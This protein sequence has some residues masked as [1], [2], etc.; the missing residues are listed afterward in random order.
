MITLE[1]AIQMGTLLFPYIIM[2]VMGILLI[3][4]GFRLASRDRRILALTGM[5]S[6]WQNIADNDRNKKDDMM[7]ERNKKV[8]AHKLIGKDMRKLRKEREEERAA[9]REELAEMTKERNRYR[10]VTDL[11]V[12][13]HDKEKILRDSDS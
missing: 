9:H 12:A 5:C 11:I 3:V 8:E 2:M 7:R 10:Q 13:A 4:S 1:T 6:Q